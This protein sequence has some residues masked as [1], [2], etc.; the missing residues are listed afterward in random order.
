MSTIKSEL[1]KIKEFKKMEMSSI[2]QFLENPAKFQ[3]ETNKRLGDLRSWIFSWKPDWLNDIIVYPASRL[4]RN[5]ILNTYPNTTEIERINLD[6]TIEQ[7][8]CF[9]IFIYPLPRNKEKIQEA[10]NSISDQF[11]DLKMLFLVHSDF[12]GMAKS[13]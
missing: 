11:Q 9:I 6:R 3:S 7:N 1:D 12:R 5:R 13:K 2:E 10:V 8:G 4:S